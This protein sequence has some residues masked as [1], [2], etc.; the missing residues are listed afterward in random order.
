[1][2]EA[3]SPI[4][5]TDHTTA[6]RTIGRSL[7]KGLCILIFLPM[8][9]V[10]LPGCRTVSKH[11]QMAQRNL[12]ESYKNGDLTREEYEEAKDRYRHPSKGGAAGDETQDSGFSF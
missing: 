8:V 6:W 4:V 1:M 12:K 2:P 10:A 7:K 11:D 5:P 3:A 9:A